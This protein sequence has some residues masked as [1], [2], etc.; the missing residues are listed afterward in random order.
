[1]DPD[2]SKKKE[3]NDILKKRNATKAELRQLHF[4]LTANSSNLY[5]RLGVIRDN[6]KVINWE[7][8]AQS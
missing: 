8:N 4:E 1:M 3:I 5:K 6:G 2:E 7:L